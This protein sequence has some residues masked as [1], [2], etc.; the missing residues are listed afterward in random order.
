METAWEGDLTGLTV[1]L[2]APGQR[3][4]GG[5]EVGCGLG[6]PGV[7]F[8]RPSMPSV[9]LGPQSVFEHPVSAPDPA[10]VPQP[11]EPGP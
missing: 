5:L 10:L 11:C 6:I 2:W 3:S 4:L 8:I 1:S 9:I 7:R